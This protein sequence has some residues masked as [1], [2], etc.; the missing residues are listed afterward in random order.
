MARLVFAWCV[1]AWSVAARADSFVIAPPW[2]QSSATDGE[3]LSD[4]LVRLIQRELSKQY[5]V[6]SPERAVEKVSAEHRTA[7][8]QGECAERYRAAHHATAA[9]VVRV[10]RE[11]DGA[12]PATSFQLG[13][14]PELGLEYSHG[15]QLSDGKLAE[16]TA[17]VL[18]DLF[19]DYRRGAG[20]FLY[21]S[22]APKGAS[23]HVDGEPM[24]TLPRRLTLSIGSHRVQVTA[25]GFQPMTRVVALSSLTSS[26]ELVFRLAPAP[27]SASAAA[28]VPVEAASLAGEPTAR[29][30]VE[31]SGAARMQN[32]ARRRRT[33]IGLMAGGAIV[34][35]LG[36]T[37]LGFAIHG[38]DESGRCEGSQL[39]CRAREESR[40][41]AR[42]QLGL[43]SALTLLGAGVLGTG[44]GMFLRDKHVQLG[45]DVGP[46]RA[47]ITLRGDL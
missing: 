5:E 47:V 45:G 37:Y 32:R 34:A 27:A 46:G 30:E 15:A 33:W 10:Y 17:R 4:E 40:G 12:G 28:V 14:Q 7:C 35:G 16:L 42:A 29:S 20:P 19:R 25:H 6:L 36:A 9:I 8:P 13:L 3:S 31:A 24:G 18:G 11:A 2:Y 1:L 22:G 21:V 26:E 41:N 38:H 39:G 23:I 43:A 44:V